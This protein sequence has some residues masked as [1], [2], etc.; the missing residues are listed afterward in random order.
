MNSI[1]YKYRSIYS[2]IFRAFSISFLV[3]VPQPIE[4]GT[5]NLC[6]DIECHKNNI[7]CTHCTQR[8]FEAAIKNVI[9]FPAPFPVHPNG[10]YR[11]PPH[12]ASM[13]RSHISRHPSRT[14]LLSISMT[15]FTYWCMWP[16]R[17]SGRGRTAQTRWF[18]VFNGITANTTGLH[19]MP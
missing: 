13:F 19:I 15:I 12:P 4:N 6:K 2:K 8:R 1:N 10:A 9:L 14:R 17:G 5:L 11:Q 7:F 16:D 18:I 3:H